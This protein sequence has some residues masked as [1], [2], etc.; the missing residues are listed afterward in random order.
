MADAD[1]RLTVAAPPPADGSGGLLVRYLSVCAALFVVLIGVVIYS[2]V[3]AGSG[4]VTISAADGSTTQVTE[5]TGPASPPPA[6]GTTD[7]P[8]EFSVS[9]A[10]FR[11][12]VTSPD[13]PVEKTAAGMFIVV[14]LTVTN[15]SDA[16]T[17]FLG[18]FQKLRA[19]GEVF[20][21]DDEA[22]FYAGGGSAELNAGDSVDVGLVFDVPPGTV[23]ESVELH[24]DPTSRGVEMSLLP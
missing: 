20:S 17:T 8:M 6:G 12:T 22:T 4:D 11:P 9:S 15:T 19:S 18:T 16:P 24:A 1:G 13:A 10:E 7:G 14:Q 23:P 3:S 21:I 5:P 2:V